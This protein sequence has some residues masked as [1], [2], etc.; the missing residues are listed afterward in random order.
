MLACIQATGQPAQRNLVVELRGVAQASGVVVSTQH[1]AADVLE[2]QMVRVKNGGQASLR[3]G[4]T[5][6]V[7]WV[8]GAAAQASSRAASGASS[9]SAGGAVANA[10]SALQAGQSLTVKPH[11]PGGKQPVTVE[12]Q[13]QQAGLDAN[14]GG[15]L[16]GQN[17]RQLSTTVVAPLDQWVTIATTGP[18]AEQRGV[19]TSKAAAQV[20]QSIQLRVSAP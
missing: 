4:S 13:V 8:Q 15:A 18:G 16:P 3:I 6:F 19:Y 7:Q 9:S 11:W 14:A 2:P 5:L 10:M 17:Q 12:V 1:S 20:P